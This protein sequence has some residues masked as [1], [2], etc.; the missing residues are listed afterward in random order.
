MIMDASWSRS[1]KITLRACRRSEIPAI[2]TLTNSAFAKSELQL[3]LTPGADKYPENLYNYSIL[4]YRKRLVEKGMRLMLT[5]DADTGEL[6]GFAVWQ[7]SGDCTLA[8]QWAREEAWWLPVERQLLDLEDKY[9][10]YVTNRSIDYCFRDELIEHM[11][12]NFDDLSACLHLVVLTVPS[13]HERKGIGRAMVR[14]GLD[15]AREEG[16]PVGLESTLAGKNLYDAE[17]FKIFKFNTLGEGTPS[18]LTIPVMLWESENGKWL[19]ED[20]SGYWVVKTA[21][22][23]Q[24]VR[25]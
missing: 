12:K 20:G 2:V 1:L 16:L 17:N 23:G 6:V 14:W 7:I 18:K 9:F 25:S 13:K 4:K 15:L 8:K 21:A 19:V 11:H 5:E 10:R 22:Y 3:R 24:A